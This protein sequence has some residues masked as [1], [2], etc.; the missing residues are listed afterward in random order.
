MSAGHVA[1]HAYLVLGGDGNEPLEGGLGGRGH[2]GG[3]ERQHGGKE[4]SNGKRRFY[5][6]VAA[7]GGHVA[8]VNCRISDCAIFSSRIYPL[9]PHKPCSHIR[10]PHSS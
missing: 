5:L 6:A 9:Y 1:G 7:G 2:G 10:S 4:M 8:P 3:A